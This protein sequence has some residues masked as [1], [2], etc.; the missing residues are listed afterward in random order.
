MA[1][2][3]LFNIAEEVMEYQGGNV[4]LEKELQ[5]I[6]ENNMDTFFGTRFLASEFPTTNGRMDSIGIDEN[7]C[8][9]IFEYKR[10]TNENVINQGLFYLNWLLDHKDS[11]KVLV[12]ERFGAKVAKQIDWSMPRVICIAGD[13]TRYDE[14][15]IKQMNRNISLIRYKKFGDDLLLFEQLDENIVKPIVSDSQQDKKKQTD[16]TF[17]EAYQTANKNIQLLF[18]DLR[19]YILRLGD[20][21]T[22][23]KLKYYVAFK[24]IKNVVCMEIYKTKVVITLKLEPSTVEMTEG[25]IRDITNVGHRASGNVQVWVSNKNE[26]EKAKSLIERAYKEN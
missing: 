17:E 15:A 5:T 12:I 6:I 1:D 11:F 24:K 23:N 16:K 22:E 7:N 19:D 10:S 25:F 3:K 26:F 13:F 18:D 14:S 8:P 4:T 9:V 21:I 20:D 2:I